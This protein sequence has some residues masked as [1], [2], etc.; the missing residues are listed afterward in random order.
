MKKRLLIVLMVFSFLVSCLIFRVGWLQ[1]I[2]GDELQK[3]A[4]EQQNSDREIPPR[5]GSI[6]DRNGKELAMSAT[7]DRV[8]INPTEIDK[9]EGERIRIAQKLS[10]FLDM[11]DEE[12]LKK[13]NRDSRYEIIKKKVEREVGNQIRQWKK[14][15]NIAGIYIDEDSKRYYPNGNIAAHVIG[16]TGEDNQ[17]LD[18]IEKTMEKYL[19]GVPGKILSEVDAFGRQ[20]PKYHKKRIDPQDGLNVVLTIDETIQY[21]ATEA[22]QK[23]LDDNQVANGG[24][25]IVMD[26]RNG[27]I[28]AMVSKPDFNLNTPRACPPGGEPETWTGSSQ[29]DIELLYKTVWRNKAVSDTYEPG[30]T[31]KSITAAIA[32]EEGV[33][34]PESRTTDKTIEVQ[35]WKINCWKPNFHG[36]E[37]FREA[38][39]NSC[40]P[41]FVR[42]ALQVGVE[43]YYRYLR[44]FGLY[45]RTGIELPGEAKGSFHENP[46]E[47]NLATAS[48]GQRFTI[49]PVELIAAYGAIA[50]GGRLIRPRLVK[51][52]IDWEGNIIERFEPE[53]IR[54][55]I[56]K[57]TSQTLMDVLEGVVSEGGGKNA[58]VKG[59]RV[60]GKTGTSETT[61]NNVY[62]ASFSAIAPADNP[63]ICVLVALDNPRGDSYYGGTIAAPVA[64]RIIED[65]L[66]YLGV[67][68]IY[69]E[70]DLEMMAEEVYVPDVRDNS[71]KDAKKILNEFGLK[72]RIEGGEHDGDTF[73]EEQTPKPGALL[74]K[75]SVVILYTDVPEEE[76]LVKVPDISNKTIEEATQTLNSAGLNIK[77]IGNGKAIKQNIEPGTQ[78][79]QGRVVEVEFLF[80]DTEEINDEILFQIE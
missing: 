19:K 64:G 9:S 61:V 46:K 35:G 3:K 12:V 60:A 76:V 57:K 37:S 47:I 36:E 38:V 42:A 4:F 79:S 62:I 63:R 44:A 10:E 59:Y 53:I 5:R 17:G 39:Y 21:F 23:A 34:T 28:L 69:N 27:E 16:F 40:N 29:E 74:A 43:K 65:T 18:G 51:E 68:R 30:S 72:Y 50:N 26:P 24:I 48:F 1:V 56:S 67:E 45:E 7:V 2:K 55:V 41:A 25:A 58:Y 75:N 54:N 22:L 32:F 11:E 71:I 33:V 20:M 14:E 66:N 70:K 49:T 15:E 52:I 78:V 73:V 6:L 31:F 77:I 13:I 8:V 80:F